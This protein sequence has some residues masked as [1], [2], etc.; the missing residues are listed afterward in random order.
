VE[1]STTYTKEIQDGVTLTVEVEGKN[2]DAQVI[3]NPNHEEDLI[4][5]FN[6]HTGATS[7]VELQQNDNAAAEV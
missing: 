2:T 5:V 6:T 4:E 3:D 7:R 1:K